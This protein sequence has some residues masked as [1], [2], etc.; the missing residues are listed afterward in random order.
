MAERA[1]ARIAVDSPPSPPGPAAA[2]WCW[3]WW[4]SS[5]DDDVEVAAEASE[6]PDLPSALGDLP[7][8]PDKELWMERGGSSVAESSRIVRSG[9][10]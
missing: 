9:W 6:A 2:L 4:C 1:A 7:W 10:E 5:D 8:W 3:L